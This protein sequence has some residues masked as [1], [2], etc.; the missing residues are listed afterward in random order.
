M[1]PTHPAPSQYDSTLT[2][3][4]ATDPTQAP[5]YQRRPELMIVKS[6]PAG[7]LSTPPQR[8]S[9]LEVDRCESNVTRLIAGYLIGYERPVSYV[10]GSPYLTRESGFARCRL[11]THATKTTVGL[12]STSEKDLCRAVTLPSFPFTLLPSHLD[13]SAIRRL[14]TGI[15]MHQRC[16][17]PLDLK[18]GSPKSTARSYA[19]NPPSFRAFDPRQLS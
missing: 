17:Q 4:R 16:I 11:P 6:K 12:R 19:R 7:E 13:C 2:A 1:E 15:N 9:V 14:G 8:P 3:L 5:A 18:L 10:H